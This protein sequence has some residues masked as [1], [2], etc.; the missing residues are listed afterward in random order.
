MTVKAKFFVASNAKVAQTNDT[1]QQAYDKIN[2]VRLSPIYS[3]G[4]IEWS[5]FTPSGSI[6]LTITNPAAADFF[7]PGKIVS[8]TFEDEAA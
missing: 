2:M 7:V 6:E 4:N 8:I 1:P 3:D 5:K